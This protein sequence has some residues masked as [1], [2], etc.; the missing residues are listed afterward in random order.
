[1]QGQ[2]TYRVCRHRGWKPDGG[3]P[4]LNGLDGVFRADTLVAAVRSISTQKPL[5][6]LPAKLGRELSTADERRE[7]ISGNIRC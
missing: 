5:G 1:M 6:I 2:E 7:R 3:E 4:S